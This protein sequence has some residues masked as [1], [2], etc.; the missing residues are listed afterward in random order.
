MVSAEN[1]NNNTII[2]LTPNRSTEWKDLKRWLIILCLPAVIVALAW[3]VAGI[4]IILPFAGL[5]LG[6]LCYF[7]LKVCYQ[8]YRVQQ[9]SIDNKKVT[10]RSGINQIKEIQSFTRPLCYLIVKQPKSPMENL[11]LSIANDTHSLNI[12]EFLNPE[13][14]EKARKS[15]I[16]AGLIECS[17]E[18]WKRSKV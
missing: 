13:D 12:G 8:N 2:T 15:L 11:E 5:E 6:L 10:V 14:R 1:L 7:M 4:W 9:I 3:L 18:W 16:Q 17:N